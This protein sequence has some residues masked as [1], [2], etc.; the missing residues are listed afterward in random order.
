MIDEGLPLG[1]EG[2]SGNLEGVQDL[3][4]SENWGVPYFGVLKIR[5]LLFRVLFWIFPYF[6][7]LP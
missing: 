4:V 2:S 3:G 1:S 5:I 7:K 6:R